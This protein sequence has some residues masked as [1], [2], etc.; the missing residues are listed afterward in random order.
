MA[1]R[2]PLLVLAGTAVWLL[3]ASSS[4]AIVCDDGGRP[5]SASTARGGPVELYGG[6]GPYRWDT[7]GK[8]V[9]FKGYD[10]AN[11]FVA[12]PLLLMA[13]RWSRRRQPRG[14]QLLAAVFAYLS[15][16]YLVGVMGNAYNGLFLIWTAL[17]SVGTFGLGV[18]LFG[19]DADALD[20]TMG[21][22]LPRRSLAV[23]LG[24]LGVFLL[25]MYLAETVPALVAGKPPASLGPYTTLELA[26]LELGLS[27]PLHLL[28]AVLLWRGKRG[29]AL[30][31]MILVIMSFMT[32]VSL[33]VAL[34][35]LVCSYQ[36]GG[37]AD[38]VMPMVCALVSGGFSFVVLRRL[39]TSGPRAALT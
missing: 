10:W 25:G 15:W 34:L 21:E 31:A 27:I 11:L 13:V 6:A 17:F 19:P 35:M 23:Y 39:G 36:Q 12:V 3:L 22:R 14:T 9:L 24:V 5:F 18:F 29:G 26:A 16:N 30:L 33:S 4:I 37:I 20:Q 28:G 32:F 1:T 8:A 7:L 38:A 2:N